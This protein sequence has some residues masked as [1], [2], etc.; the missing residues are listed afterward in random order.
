MHT[1]K[2][3]WVPT[4]IHSPSQGRTLSDKRSDCYQ[5]TVCHARCCVLYVHWLL[6]ASRPFLVV[7]A[8]TSFTLQMRKQVGRS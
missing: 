1:S 6:W 4:G 3:P 5:I 2:G 7:G 8:V